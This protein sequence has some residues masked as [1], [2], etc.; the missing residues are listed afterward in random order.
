MSFIKRDTC[1][2]DINF[3]C[4][5]SNK[6]EVNRFVD[7]Y[8]KETNETI[9]L[10]YKKKDKQRSIFSVKATYRCHPDTRYE[11]AREVDTVLDKNP[12]KRFRNTNC[13]FQ[14]TLKFLKDHV[15]TLSCNVFIK[16][17]HNHA[18]NS[19][20]ALSFKILSTEIK[21]E[22]EALF[23]SGLT[24]SQAYDEFL[25]NLQSNS[26]NELNFHLK[27]ADRSKCPRRRDFNSLY[28]KYYREKSGGRNGAEMFDKL[29][30]RTNEF[31]ESNEGVKISYRLYNKDQNLALILAIVPPLMQRVH[32]KVIGKL[33][34]PKKLNKI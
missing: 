31:M 7:F 26:E 19:L 10:K 2:C 17:Y 11:G 27:K 21:M 22:F 24:P 8:M 15:N 29:E 34:F 6:E 20:E 1:S 18:V 12:F 13:P 23:S 14:I 33:I 30:E 32:S 5:V 9:K 16:H 28:I 25:R 4:N 3:N